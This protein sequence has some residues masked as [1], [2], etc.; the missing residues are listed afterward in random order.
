M[1]AWSIF[2]TF[3]LATSITPWQMHLTCTNG[4]TL[5]QVVTGCGTLLREKSYNYC[6][7]SMLLD[8]R[9]ILESVKSIDI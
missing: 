1:G 6:H 3:L 9:R 7:D 4:A 8:L 5:G 2:T